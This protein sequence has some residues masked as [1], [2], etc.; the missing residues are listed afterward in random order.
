MQNK[1]ERNPNLKPSANISPGSLLGQLF[2]DTI[3][4][5][6]PQ[7][8]AATWNPA[9]PVADI[10]QPRHCLHTPRSTRRQKNRRASSSAA[11]QEFP[12]EPLQNTDYK[13]ADQVSKKKLAPTSAQ[14]TVTVFEDFELCDFNSS[15][16]A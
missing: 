15:S 3:F 16:L 5:R 1:A 12:M 2:T 9:V 8:P 13:A 7:P 14:F 4:P 11:P 10:S 6:P